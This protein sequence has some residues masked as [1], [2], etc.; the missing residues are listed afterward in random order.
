[1]LR[2]IPIKKPLI[3]VH[4]NIDSRRY[5]SVEQIR[6]YLP[7]QLVNAVK[8]EQTMHVLYDRDPETPY[9]MTYECGPGKSLKAI[10]K[11]TNAKAA[12]SAYNVDV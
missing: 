10:L 5:R 8:W 11:M 2:E 6:N 12:Q 7:R 4:S 9:P 3:H 1:M